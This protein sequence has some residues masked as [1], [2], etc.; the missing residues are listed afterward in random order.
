MKDRL[1][2]NTNLR[3]IYGVSALLLLLLLA[4]CQTETQKQCD[5]S[6]IPVPDK[7]ASLYE[8]PLILKEDGTM[9]GSGFVI[10]DGEVVTV[11]HV[12]RG[13]N[14]CGYV[15][16]GETRILPLD[17]QNA[18]VISKEPQILDTLVEIPV[19]GEMNEDINSIAQFEP[20]IGDQLSITGSVDQGEVKGTVVAARPIESVSGQTLTMKLMGKKICPGDSGGPVYNDKGEIV[21]GLFSGRRA[22]PDTFLDALLGRCASGFG[23]I[24][25]LQPDASNQNLAP[26]E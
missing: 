15:F 3:S 22:P 7:N 18:T 20:Q 21:G 11:G 1:F 23:T 16:F 10:H 9:V 4:S 24:I 14:Q 17:I 2:Q 25:E 5:Y 6:S 12:A 8:P 19:I 26:L 13:L